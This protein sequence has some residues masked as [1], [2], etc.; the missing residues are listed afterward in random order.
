MGIS[1]YSI[2]EKELQQMY[3]QNKYSKYYFNI[4]SNAKSRTL[5]PETYIERHHIIPKSLGGNNSKDNLVSLTA[6]EHFVC[7]LLLPK[8]TTGQAQIKMFHA[9][10]RMC[11]KGKNSKHDYKMTSTIYEKL[12]SQRAEYLKTLT[13]PLNPN[14]GRKTG[15]TSEDFTLEWREKLSLSRQGQSSWNKGIAR[16]DEEVSKISVTRKLRAGTPGWNVRP[17]CSDEKAEKIKQS[18][19][20]KRWV[21]NKET[22][23]RKYISPELFNEYISLGWIPGLGP[24][25]K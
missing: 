18:L 15:R 12:K 8:M 24:R 17:P 1:N 2:T 7:H 23:D 11:C 21:H 4:V 20:G 25:T 19:I 22:C 14:Y 9:A 13:G 16:T 6:R 10:W 5:S 3:L